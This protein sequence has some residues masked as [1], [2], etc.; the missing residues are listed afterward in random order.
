M[1]EQG[2][3]RR[4]SFIH[5][6]LLLNWKTVHLNLSTVDWIRIGK[7]HLFPTIG[8]SSLSCSKC[9]SWLMQNIPHYNSWK[10][11]SPLRSK[12][13]SSQN[14]F[15]RSNVNQNAP[16]I[17]LLF[18]QLLAFDRTIISHDKSLIAVLKGLIFFEVYKACFMVNLEDSKKHRKKKHRRRWLRR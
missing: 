15:R 1:H 14:A 6:S 12:I 9:Q 11:H 2:A 3:A 10:G 18:D 7:R 16:L 8:S 4:L 17:C 5:I 13:F